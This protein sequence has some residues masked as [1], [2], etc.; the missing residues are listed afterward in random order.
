MHEDFSVKE[1]IYRIIGEGINLHHPCES[2]VVAFDVTNPKS[3]KEVYREAGRGDEDLKKM[4]RN[5]RVH[6]KSLA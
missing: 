1:R 2:L 5:A 3:P 6:I 4:M